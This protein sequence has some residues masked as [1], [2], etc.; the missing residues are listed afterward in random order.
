MRLA[1]TCL[2]R[3]PQM[4]TR[5]R[6]GARVAAVC[7]HAYVSATN[8]T[9]HGLLS[10]VHVHSGMIVCGVVGPLCGRG[11]ATLSATTRQH[12]RGGARVP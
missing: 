4:H 12:G 8:C 2:R 3:H 9:R 6:L 11:F 5:A 1:A 7:V 10:F